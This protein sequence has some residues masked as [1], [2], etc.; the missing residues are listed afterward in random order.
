MCFLKR[1]MAWAFG[2]IPLVSIFILSCLCCTFLVWDFH[3][4][5]AVLW[6]H[7]VIWELSPLHS[8]SLWQLEITEFSMQFSIVFLCHSVE[9]LKI[10]KFWHFLSKSENAKTWLSHV[11]DDSSQINDF[12][13]QLQQK[14]PSSLLTLSCPSRKKANSITF[15]LFL[16]IYP[17]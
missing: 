4:K 13:S 9:S 12:Q 11:Q 10:A 6:M 2:H 14:L 16:Y 5:E 15:S 3:R 1:A 17:I 8:H 7:T